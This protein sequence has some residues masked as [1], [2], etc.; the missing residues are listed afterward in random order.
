MWGLILKLVTLLATAVD[1]VAWLFFKALTACPRRT[2]DLT[3][4]A[5]RASTWPKRPSHILFVID[6]PLLSYKSLADLITWAMV[7]GV[8]YIS[9]YD[10]RGRLHQNPENLLAFVQR[11]QAKCY[12]KWAASHA[13]EQLPAEKG[14]IVETVGQHYL[15]TLGPQ[16]SHSNIVEAARSVSKTSGRN[17]KTKT[18]QAELH[19]THVPEPELLI[20]FGNR[21]MLNYTMPWQ[22]R[23][24]EMQFLYSHHGL[25]QSQLFRCLQK[26][27][28]CS[29]RFG[30]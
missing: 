16:H 27:A 23:V 15:A 3:A 20:K 18:L 14:Q 30:R 11:H 10:T 7:Y 17:A 21:D 9:V 12:A 6:E 2:P 19:N 24:T 1:T 26:Y 22:L 25:H 28:K 4:V 29:Q 5:Q 13:I 8:R